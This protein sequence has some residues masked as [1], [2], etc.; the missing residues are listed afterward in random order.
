MQK[1]QIC[2][3]QIKNHVRPHEVLMI[4]HI[5]NKT[6][7]AAVFQYCFKVSHILLSFNKTGQ[8]LMAKYVLSTEA[9]QIKIY[10]YIVSYLYHLQIDMKISHYLYDT[11][12]KKANFKLGHLVQK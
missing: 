4:E 7:A 1:C 10:F 12:T 9:K 11:A 3:G 5:Y 2:T 6:N 8:D